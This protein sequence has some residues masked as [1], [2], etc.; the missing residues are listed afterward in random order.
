MVNLEHST[1]TVEQSQ[2]SNL[3]SK[4]AIGIAV[5][6]LTG[7]SST[8]QF[9]LIDTDLHSTGQ[10]SRTKSIWNEKRERTKQRATLNN[11]GLE[12]FSDQTGD[13]IN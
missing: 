11:G 12:I 5:T 13:M 2:K 7:Y 9:S 8:S 3:R 1:I 4:V 10:W 6:L